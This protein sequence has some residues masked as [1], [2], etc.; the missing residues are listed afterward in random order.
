MRGTVNLMGAYDSHAW[1]ESK[2][3]GSSRTHDRPLMWLDT[4]LSCVMH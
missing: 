4:I 2:Q 3:A 1:I